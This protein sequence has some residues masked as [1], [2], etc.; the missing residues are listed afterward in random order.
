MKAYTKVANQVGQAEFPTFHISYAFFQVFGRD[1]V[2]GSLRPEENLARLAHFF[3]VP[4]ESLQDQCFECLPFVRPLLVRDSQSLLGRNGQQSSLR[5]TVAAWSSVLVKKYRK[6]SALTF[7]MS[8]YKLYVAATAR[9]EQN[10]AVL[11][12]AFGEQRLD[13]KEDRE[14]RITKLI[15]EHLPDSDPE[16][17]DILKRAQQLYVTLF[18]FR[19]HRGNY[20]ERLDTGVK[21]PVNNEGNT[22]SAWLRRRDESVAGAV[23]EFESNNNASHSSLEKTQARIEEVDVGQAWTDQH[24]SMVEKQTLKAEA[25]KADAILDDGYDR[26]RDSDDNV[27]LQANRRHKQRIQLA[28]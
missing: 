23:A 24:R 17:Q 12:R 7:V 4:T 21:K 11:K 20:S 15:L 22:E 28:K 2:L 6:G 8:R 5:K 9:V 10:F 26:Q 13:L 1:T 18:M 27:Q 19:G 25:R 16:K 3:S 14:S